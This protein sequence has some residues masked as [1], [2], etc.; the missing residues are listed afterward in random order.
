MNRNMFSRV[1]VCFPI[2]NKKHKERIMHNL[3]YYLKD[4]SQ[5]W[6]LQPDGSYR[7][8]EPV[9]APG[10]QVQSALLEELGK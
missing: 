2:E 7:R 9:E 5:A 3:G 6:L 4:D 1:E 10:F 8:V